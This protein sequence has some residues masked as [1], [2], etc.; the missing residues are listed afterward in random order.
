MIGS[1]N[2]FLAKDIVNLVKGLNPNPV[3]VFYLSGESYKVFSA[4][5]VQYIGDE[6]NGIILEASAKKGFVIKCEGGAVEIV[7]MTAPNSK[8]ML[9]KSYLNG[10]QIK[11]GS[12]V[13]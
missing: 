6:K 1:I 4:K 9:A 2:N 10:K 3:A 5:E 8:K 7:E 12:I 13:E 11:V